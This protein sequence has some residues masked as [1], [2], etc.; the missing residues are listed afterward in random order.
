[1]LFR[2]ICD[3]QAV[4]NVKNSIAFI[5]KSYAVVKFESLKEIQACT[6]FTVQGHPTTVSSDM[7]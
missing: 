4:S 6:G 3:I 2:S 5:D 7:D 1:M